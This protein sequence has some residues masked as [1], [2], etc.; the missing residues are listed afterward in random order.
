[1]EL[2]TVQQVTKKYQISARM[3]RYYEKIGLLQSSRKEGYAYRVYDETAQRRIGQILIL[4]KL[5]V[6]M[7]QIGVILSEPAATEAIEIFKQNISEL[8]GEIH[9]LSV[10]RDILARLAAELQEKAHV[11]LEIDAL[12]ESPVLSVVQSLS[13]S[14]TY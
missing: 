4:R 6:S 8:E 1:M 12:M 9:A 13:L 2:Q 7:K 3:L 11:R 5:R 14:K 10:I